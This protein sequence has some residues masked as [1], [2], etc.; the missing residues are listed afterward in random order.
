[1]ARTKG[2][3]AKT[4]IT[5]GEKYNPIWDITTTEQVRSYFEECVRHTLQ[6]R[7]ELSRAAA[8]SIE[9]Q[10]IGYYSGYGNATE[11]RRVLTLFD[12]VHPIFGA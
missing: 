4:Q 1:M 5:I 8:E 12:V 10:N 7:P 3:N 6:C 2:D 9:R 11:A